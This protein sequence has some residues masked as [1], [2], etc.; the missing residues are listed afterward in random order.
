MKPSALRLLQM[1]TQTE[2]KSL[3]SYLQNRLLNN[4]KELPALFDA[5]GEAG[6]KAI[7]EAALFARAFPNKVFRK[8][9][10]HLYMSRLQDAT[11][12]FL[13]WRQFKSDEMQ[14]HLFALRALRRLRVPIFF[15]RRFRQA[16]KIREKRQHYEAA[17]LLWDYQLELEYYDYRASPNR[18]DLTNLQAVSDKLD[19]FFI[20]EK[21][22]LACL[23][24]S[25][26]LANQ[27]DYEL[28]YLPF[29]LADLEQRPQLLD[30]PAIKIYASCYRAVAAG[31]NEDDFRELRR[32][33]DRYRKGFPK[34][35]LRDIYLLAINFCIRALNK[36]QT[37]FMQDIKSLYQESLVEG[38]LLED[39]HLPESTF[40][41]MIALHLKLGD[42]NDSAAIME[43]YAKDLPPLSRESTLNFNRARWHHAQGQYNQALPLLAQVETNAPYLYLGAKSLQLRIFYEQG[44]VDACDSV[45]AQLRQYLH[46][47][48]NLGYRRASY[49]LML[50]FFRQL[51]A[52]PPGDNHARTMLLEHVE[53][54]ETF[55]EKAWFVGQLGRGTRV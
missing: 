39:G 14:Q 52:L 13:A 29:I 43:Q 19:H 53:Q 26:F 16:R 22:R 24:H 3:R 30:I 31:G 18:Q 11:E 5:Y 41:N 27:E 4:R 17:T 1:L 9:D 35:E 47:R 23:A 15:D 8:R 54:A 49:Q 6:T 51:L 2:L 42:Y 20:A 44:S 50:R 45:L 12:A 55:A 10:W 48:K 38:Y 25:R 34:R 7:D 46:R 37:T 21:L 33:M 28:H 40:T 36:G 32:V